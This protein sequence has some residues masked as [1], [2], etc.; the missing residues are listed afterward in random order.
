MRIILIGLALLIGC[1]AQSKS[2]D[3]DTSSESSTDIDAGNES[4]AGNDTDSESLEPCLE[5]GETK[6]VLNTF[7]ECTDG[8][9]VLTRECNGDTP[10][11]HDDLSCLVCEPN[12][13][14]CKQGSEAICSADGMD[15]EVVET[16]DELSS[17]IKG[18]CKNLCDNER[19]IDSYLGCEFISVT[20][21]NGML[22][23]SFDND[24]AI[25]VGNPNEFNDAKVTVTQGDELLAE[26]EILPNETESI[27]LPMQNRLKNSMGTVIVEK[28][29]F[30]VAST[31]PI[32]AYQY[33]PFHFKTAFEGSETVS[34]TND[35]SLLIPESTLGQEYIV[36]T[37]NTWDQSRLS[38]GFASITA[39]ENNT[40]VT[41]VS[42]TYTSTGDIK[43]LL[44]GD[45]ATVVLNRGDVLQVL[46]GARLDADLTGTRVQATKNV[47]V[48]AG[49]NCTNIP[50]D[51]E[52]CC[53][54]MEEMMLPLEKW[55][56]DFIMASPVTP[57]TQIGLAKV[58]YRVIARDDNTE[59][60]I[61]PK[62]IEPTVLNEKEILEFE[63]REAFLITGRKNG[64]PAQIHVTQTMLSSYELPQRELG[65]PAMT[66]GIPLFQGRE[67]YYFLVPDTYTENYV[68]IVA[69]MDKNIYLNDEVVTGWLPVGSTEYAVANIRLEPGSYVAK[70]DNNTFFM[71]TAYGYAPYTSYYYPGGLDLAG[72]VE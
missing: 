47:A 30:E 7:Y 66:T 36:S 42:N 67:S 59:I 18:M 52:C 14:T 26:V 15:S 27:L 61:D 40:E 62:I 45:T 63:T 53:D 19:E 50:Q 51:S 28:G 55:G 72:F 49:H 17:C 29:A 60:A 21:V 70:S 1:S 3:D 38:P 13:K 68:G 22:H 65:D 57:N 23:G 71:I 9:W 11:C 31:V 69:P 4:D 43:A 39:T 37:W 10:F 64:A 6:C 35:A 16:C 54:H 32:V 34:L 44:P 46:S 58:I 5:N 48:F 33:N 2:R 20:T 25:V 56:A 41:I 24:F 12:A 8:E